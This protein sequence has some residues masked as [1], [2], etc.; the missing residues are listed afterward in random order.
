MNR[1]I[2]AHGIVPVVDSRHAFEPAADS[3]ARCW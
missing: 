3:Y 2:E 1:A